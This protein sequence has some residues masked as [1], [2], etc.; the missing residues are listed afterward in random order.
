MKKSAAPTTK[1]MSNKDKEKNSRTEIVK[2]KIFNLSS[3]TLLMY[4]TNILLGDLKFTP[5]LSAII[6]KF[7]LT[8]K[9][10]RANEF[11]QNKEANYSEENPF[12]KPFTFTPPR[13]RDRD[14]DDQIVVLNN[15]NLENGDQNLEAIFLIW[16]KKDFQN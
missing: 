3:K 10:T 4:Q 15:L 6:L 8:Y 11:L 13:N 7:N 2:P 14:L 9:I 16:N 1:G 12:Q 5:T